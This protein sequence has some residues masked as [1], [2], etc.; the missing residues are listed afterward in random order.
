M[1]AA[2]A[3]EEAAAVAAEEV[4]EPPS[5][6]VRR[7][8]DEAAGPSSGAC[9]RRRGGG[10]LSGRCGRARRWRLWA[11]E[12]VA[13]DLLSLVLVTALSGMTSCPDIRLA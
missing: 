8:N 2:P 13:P 1:E 7:L 5:P 12:L 3:V 11:P 4:P 9:A 10:R 6:K